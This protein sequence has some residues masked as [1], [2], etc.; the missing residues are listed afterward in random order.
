MKQDDYKS[1][2]D[3]RRHQTYRHNYQNL[4]PEAD[5]HYRALK[6][7]IERF[8]LESK[9]C[10]EIGSSGGVFQDMVH[11]YWGTDIAEVLS[12]YYRKPYRIAEGDKYPFED[13]AFDAIWTINVFEHIPHLQQ[14]LQEIKRLLKSG[15]V[16]FFEPAWQC[17][18]WAAGGYAV[19]GYRELGVRGKLVKLSIPIRDSVFWRILFVAPKR[20]WRHVFFLLGYRNKIVKYKKLIANYETFWGSDADACNHIDPHDAILWFESNGFECVS[21]PL[22]LRAV[23]VRTGHLIF[24]KR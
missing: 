4:S 1:F 22:H 23:L 12:K 7:F 18:S 14:A 3:E 21:H 5:P 10:L 20:A 19:R 15:G 2:Y 8:D 13:G 24:R 16:I 9:T 17:R 6:A 11:D